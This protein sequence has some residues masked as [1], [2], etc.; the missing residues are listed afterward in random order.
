MSDL[1][2]IREQLQ[3]AFVIILVLQYVGPIKF[4][5]MPHANA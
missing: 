2:F 5:T 3:K 1:I 4:H